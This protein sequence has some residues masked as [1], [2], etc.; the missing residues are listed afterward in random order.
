M[1]SESISKRL[2]KGSWIAKNSQIGVK[3]RSKIA[4]LFFNPRCLTSHPQCPA[5]DFC[6]AR[7]LGI[8]SSHVVSV[9][10]PCRHCRP[11]SDWPPIQPGAELGT[12]FWV[13]PHPQKFYN[14]LSLLNFNHI[15]FTIMH[16]LW[17]VAPPLFFST[18]APDY[19]LP[20]ALSR[21]ST[22]PSPSE[23]NRLTSPVSTLLRSH[24]YPSC[25]LPIHP[26]SSA[27]E[28]GRPRTQ[29]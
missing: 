25:M 22:Y 14:P 10:S 2:C 11:R 8:S 12:R 20:G 26:R 6:W 18:S 3:T 15:C 23:S 9:L 1:H 21:R 24:P 19:S 28:L 5:S 4:S 29:W 7:R 13:R 16:I 17:S 27:N